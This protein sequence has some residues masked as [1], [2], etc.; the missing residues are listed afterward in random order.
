MLSR[1]THLHQN[2]DMFAARSPVHIFIHAKTTSLVKE[3]GTKTVES[4]FC[5]ALSDYAYDFH[6]GRKFSGLKDVPSLG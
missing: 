1:Q 6:Q 4:V 5:R 3:E 2:A